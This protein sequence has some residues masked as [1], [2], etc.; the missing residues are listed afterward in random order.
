M[1]HVVDPPIGHAPL[2][3]IQGGEFAGFL[4]PQAALH[5]QF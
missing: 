5:Q 4:H 1:E 3:D 2:E